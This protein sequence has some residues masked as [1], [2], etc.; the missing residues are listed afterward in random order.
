VRVLPVLAVVA[1]LGVGLAVGLAMDGDDLGDRGPTAAGVERRLRHSFDGP[2]DGLISVKCRRSS[3]RGY[4]DC[5]VWFAGRGRR[6]EP[7]AFYG[8][9]FVVPGE[10]P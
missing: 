5:G 9:D 3:K 1:A 8:Y 4:F 7:E 10:G 6:G 2:G